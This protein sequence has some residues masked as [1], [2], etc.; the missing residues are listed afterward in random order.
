MEKR[1]KKL[2]ALA[3][4]CI[5]L[6]GICACAPE[7]ET[8]GP[9]SD[10]GNGE[11]VAP[12]TPDTIVHA[13]GAYKMDAG[14]TIGFLS[15]EIETTSDGAAV[16]GVTVQLTATVEP[17][18]AWNKEVDWSFAWAEDAPTEWSSKPAENYIKIEP[19]T[20]GSTTANV[21][22]TDYYHAC[23]ITITV[24]TRD[25]GF[26]S[27]CDATCVSEYYETKITMLGGVGKDDI[28]DYSEK[29]GFCDYSDLSMGTDRLNHQYY[30]FY[31]VS[32]MA[33]SYKH[34]NK[35]GYEC[36]APVDLRVKFRLWAMF[37]YDEDKYQSW[38]MD[39][40]RLIEDDP[41]EY[42]YALSGEEK[43]NFGFFP[44]IDNITASAYGAA[45]MGTRIAKAYEYLFFQVFEKEQHV[46]CLY[47]KPFDSNF[48]Y[49]TGTSPS[50]RYEFTVADLEIPETVI[51]GD[52]H[53]GGLELSIGNSEVTYVKLRTSVS[54]VSLS[55]TSLALK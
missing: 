45:N 39:A 40:S 22:L 48:L 33:F 35:F 3:L 47:L 18:D 20:D 52:S 8:D 11:Y 4:S 53:T 49:V 42:S 55:A 19:L 38:Y 1:F 13:G 51:N 7:G 6:L 21:T 50:A 41:Y 44:S 2:L 34:Y 10:V 43:S 17:A 9:I 25:G 28:L 12:I 5:T 54:A 27:S 16:E 26:T 30:D 46:L 23:A 14:K 36:G 15:S 37:N 24:T 32:A 31:T 29:I